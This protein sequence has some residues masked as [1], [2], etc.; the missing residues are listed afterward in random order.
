MSRRAFNPTA[1]QR[2]WVEAMVAYGVPEAEICRLIK[3]PQ[4]AEPIDLETL[5]KHFAAEI[6]TGRVKTNSLVGDPIIAAILG[7]D[8][9]LLDDRE[10]VR[11]AIFFAKTRM[12]W[13][14]AKR[15]K[16]VCDPIDGEDARRRLNSKIAR[17]ARGLKA[18]E[19]GGS[20]AG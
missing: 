9:G 5:R 12:G 20:S 3:N 13:T 8:G 7:R 6:A 14:V 4:T 2:G 11:L 16:L 1:E 18:G 10:R 15:P 17:L 19:T